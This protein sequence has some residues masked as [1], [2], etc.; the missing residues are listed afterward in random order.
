VR[1]V[2]FTATQYVTL[3]TGSPN[4]ECDC[5]TASNSRIFSGRFCQFQ[6]TST[7]DEDDTS[8]KPLFCVNNGR[9]PTDGSKG[10]KCDD[11][12]YGIH[13]DYMENPEDIPSFSP[14]TVSSNA[15]EAP[16]GNPTEG[17]LPTDVPATSAPVEG[18]PLSVGPSIT[19]NKDTRDP[20]PT[21]SEVTFEPPV[22]ND[23][24]PYPTGD[25]SETPVTNDP[26]PSPA[27]ITFEPPVANDPQPTPTE[28]SFEP[29][30]TAPVPSITTE[31][32][33][34]NLCKLSCKNNGICRK[35]QKSLGI[36]E[37]IAMCIPE[38]NKTS[39]S[40]FE[41]CECLTGFVGLQ[42]EH[43]MQVCPGR[44][45]VCLHGSK[46]V[47]YGEEQICD[48]SAAT[49]HQLAGRSCQHKSFTSC[50]KDESKFIQPRSFCVNGGICLKLVSGNQDHPGCE[51]PFEEWTGP[52]CELH[53]PTAKSVDDSSTLLNSNLQEQ[54]NSSQSAIL[55]FGILSLIAAIVVS[56]FTYYREKRNR[57][58][59][60]SSN[61]APSVPQ[62]NIGPPRDED[63][64]E[65]HQ[66]N[67]L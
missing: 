1:L 49:E 8:S 24:Q 26:Q 54:N 31:T 7:C 9:C 3:F 29:P 22:T 51:C 30:V 25:I 57:M 27:E 47:N 40:D 19:P 46:C 13:C 6:A 36:I 32:P 63:G 61:T 58:R 44:K 14:S 50:N 42:C 37:S 10:C 39:N 4:Y 41:H 66:I 62:V 34:S 64:N 53:K 17:N 35:G 52:H 67:I 28:I 33:N 38:L 48:C 15:P 5:S 55:A 56:I 65:L 12:F 11:H 21:P 59:E 16:V 18:Q 20:Q 60:I 2:F 43:L 23:P 45:H